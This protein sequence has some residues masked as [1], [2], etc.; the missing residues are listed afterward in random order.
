MNEITK[1]QLG[2]QAFIMAVEAHKE[3]QAYLAEIKK[4]VGKSKDVLE[5]VELRMAE[6]LTERGVSGD[7]V[8]QTKDVSYLKKQLGEPHDFVDEVE[9]SEA[10]N[11]LMSEDGPKR[12]FRDTSHGIIAGVAA[13]LGVYLGI[14]ALII[15]LLF[16]V[17]TFS[18]GAGVLLYILLWLLV[19]EAKTGS[20]RLQMSGKAVTLSSIKQ[21]VDRA[22]VPGAAHRA[23][24]MFG[25]TI[26]GVAKLLLSILGLSFIVIAASMFVWT[27]IVGLY[28]LIHGSQ[29]NSSV[30]FPIGARET[31]LLVCGLVVSSMLSLLCLLIG[32]AMVRRKC[33]VPGWALAAIVG[34]FLASA[35]VGTALG[36]DVAPG[37]AQRVDALHHTKII[38]LPAFKNA[39][40]DGKETEF[41]FQPDT[42]Y[43]V[44]LRYLGSAPQP[45]ALDVSVKGETLVV[46]TTAFGGLP[47]CQFLCIYN[48]RHVEV[49]VHAPA[50]QSV[51]VGAADDDVSF[52]AREQLH[53]SDL[54]L[55][56]GKT[57]AL[58]LR[59]L[60]SS[61]IVLS[62]SH[63]S[64]LRTLDISG[65]RPDSL[66]EGG[67]DS[68]DE[69]IHITQTDSLVLTTDACNEDEAF[70]YLET[71]PTELRI[72]K[73]AAVDPATFR[74]LHNFGQRSPEN[75]VVVR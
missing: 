38:N 15:R 16:V 18:G 34:V 9:T 19:P 54:H 70:V 55:Q 2:E 23:S 45:A 62:A 26:E 5:E 10:A 4:Q 25:K 41:V 7:T 63:S 17:L 74:N 47:D 71:V 66:A 52:T 39:T 36:F 58:H 56:A 28:A 22:D 48:D 13:G 51:R 14:D 67:I 46:D 30:I 40:L 49:V 27:A 24:H 57:V 35:S 12:L 68:N 6:L 1:V 21:A 65:I 29:V 60:H 72:N 69:A 33:P 3:L 59:H 53:Q 8:V 11:G 75:C 32:V 43:S 31:W 73:L 64:A 50:L 20:D 42:H 61:Q 44:E 37:I